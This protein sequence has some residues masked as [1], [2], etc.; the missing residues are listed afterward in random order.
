MTHSS[1]AKEFRDR[2]ESLRT[3]AK[4]FL[5]AAQ[6]LCR[7]ADDYERMAAELEPTQSATP[8]V[9]RPVFDSDASAHLGSGI[10]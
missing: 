3:I 1:K 4:T 7:L 10:H 2:A 5:N 8:S 9:A 6:G